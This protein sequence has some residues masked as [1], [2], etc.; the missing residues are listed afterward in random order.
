MRGLQHH[1][2]SAAAA[3][4]LQATYL[5]L[6]EELYIR[7]GDPVYPMP[8]TSGVTHLL[9]ALRGT[10]GLA[11]HTNPGTT[12]SEGQGYAMLLAGFLKDVRSLK[13]LTV[14]WQ[15]ILALYAFLHADELRSHRQVLWAVALIQGHGTTRGSRRPRYRAAESE[16]RT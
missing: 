7:E 3:E 1:Y 13:G 5:P 15:A 9:H 8:A 16:P 12:V 2:V 4:H 14:G 10:K 6:W 11:V